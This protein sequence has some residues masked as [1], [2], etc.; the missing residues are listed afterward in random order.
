MVGLG[1]SALALGAGGS[2]CGPAEEQNADPGSS[3]G[4]NLVF[5]FADQWRAQATGYGGNRD[6]LTPNLDRLA[7]EAVN[8]SNAVSCCP[9]CSPHRAGLLTGQYPLTHGVFLNDA[10]LTDNDTRS[11]LAH[12]FADA[13][14]RTG[15]IGKW[16]LN[17]DRDAFIPVDHRLGFEFWRAYGCRH[18]Y[19]K[20]FYYGD[21]PERKTWEGYEVFAQTR[22][23]QQFLHENA[24]NKFMLMMSWGPP[25][26]PYEDV[27]QKYLDLFNTTELELRANV[28]KQNQQTAL[29]ILRG[30]YAHIAAMDQCVG[31]LLDTLD[32][33]GLGDD[34]IFVFSSDH[35]DMIYSHGRTKK[36]QPEDE[37]ARVPFLLRYPRVLGD[38]ATTISF[39]INTPDIM[40]TLLGLSRLPVPAGVEGE[41]LSGVLRGQERRE[42]NAALICAISPFGAWCRANGGREY[43]GLRTRRYTYTRDLE[44][45]WLLF[46]NQQD[47]YQLKNLCNASDYARV[48]Q[49]LD[50]TLSRMLVRLGDE[51]KPG[52]HYLD[53]FGYQ[54]G[55]DG[56]LPH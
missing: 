1:T 7:Q 39:P 10:P 49:Q 23:A 12:V 27:P 32:A 46:D 44:G 56:S 14:Y 35:G 2:G 19:Q 20:G 52:D 5:V 34:T 33:L 21:T 45:P 36:Q 41:D 8:F 15:F 24:S 16:H 55:P 9:V 4:P 54:V 38:R 53:T 31:E 47:P 40:P 11:S 48:Q 51:F 3:P 13:G 25:H 30:Y 43:R 22:A 42:D 17:G 37:S 29:K 26:G 28:P 6:V 18:R 50:Q